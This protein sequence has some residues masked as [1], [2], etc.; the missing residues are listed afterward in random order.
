MDLLTERGSQKGIE[1]LLGMV[2]NN[3]G[4]CYEQGAL[5]K[6]LI[7]NL[8][9]GLELEIMRG[10]SLCIYLSQKLNIQ[11]L[12]AVSLVELLHLAFHEY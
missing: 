2:F 11:F 1:K 3:A 6:H 9:F 12:T 7:E 4:G 10:M 5:P 8:D